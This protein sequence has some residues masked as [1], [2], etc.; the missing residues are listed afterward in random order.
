MCESMYQQMSS[1]LH[2]NTAVS[3]S[4]SHLSTHHYHIPHTHTHAHTHIHMHIHS[5]TYSVEFASA[6][7]STYC[8]HS[9]VTS[10]CWKGNTLAT[11]SWDSTV[12]VGGGLAHE[13]AGHEEVW[14]GEVGHEEVWHGEVGHEEV[15][16]EEVG[17]EEV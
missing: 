1:Y 14:H 6:V 16:H 13:E 4:S 12:K 5:Y 15:W 7:N 9:S 11:A 8:H 10:L 2:F 3:N 17:C